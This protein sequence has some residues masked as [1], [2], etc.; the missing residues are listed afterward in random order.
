MKYAFLH[1]AVCQYGTRLLSTIF[2]EF[3]LNSFARKLDGHMHL[4][5]HVLLSVDA[6]TGL[7][8][9]LTIS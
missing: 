1:D 9:N 8:F 2:T 3:A 4:L 5:L 6:I 7:D